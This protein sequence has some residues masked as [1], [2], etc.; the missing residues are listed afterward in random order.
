MNIETKKKISKGLSALSIVLL[1][2]YM[3][4]DWSSKDSRFL[5]L[6]PWISLIVSSLYSYSIQ[7]EIKELEKADSTKV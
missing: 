6:V 5:N 7:K 3:I 1:L 4:F 2:S